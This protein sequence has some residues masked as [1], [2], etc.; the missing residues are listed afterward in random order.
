M[1]LKTKICLLLILVGLANLF[2]YTVAYSVVGGESVRGKISEDPDT[3]ERRY[4]L[5]QGDEVTRG[6]FVYMGIHSI[7]VWVAIGAIMLSM[8]TLAKDNIA[9]SL[10]S[11][12][13][14]GRTLCTVLAVV[15]GI[16][17]G[18]M[19]FRFIDQFSNHFKHPVIEKI[20]P[21]APVA[22]V[23]PVKD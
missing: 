23:A 3:G 2:A 1:E 12:A 14:R 7:S 17:I 5:D 16:S 6:E 19:T 15:I 11:A 10:K 9:D 22:P 8:L 20:A 21:P 13:M 4:F 18:G